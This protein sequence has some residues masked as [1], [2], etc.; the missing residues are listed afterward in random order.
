MILLRIMNMNE[1]L[2]FIVII[3][4]CIFLCFIKEMKNFLNIENHEGLE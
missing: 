3:Y 1:K 4:D 2:H